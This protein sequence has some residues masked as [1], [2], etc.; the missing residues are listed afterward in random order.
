MSSPK[1]FTLHR[2]MWYV[3]PHLMTPST[4]TPSPHPDPLQNLPGPSSACTAHPGETMHK[5]RLSALW[6][7][8]VLNKHSAENGWESCVRPAPICP[9]K[10]TFKPSNLI[11]DENIQSTTTPCKK[12]LLQQILCPKPPQFGSEHGG[13]SFSSSLLA[14]AGCS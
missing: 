7:K 8:L 12:S 2:A 6:R 1:T 13:N 9:K 3:T 4:G 11:R 5:T 14:G 10:M